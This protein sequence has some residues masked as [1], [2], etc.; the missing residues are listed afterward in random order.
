MRQFHGLTFF[1][2]STIARRFG[3]GVPVSRQDLAEDLQLR[4]ESVA[5]LADHLE[6]EGLILQVSQ[7]GSEDVGLTLALSPEKI[8]LARL[9]E[10]GAR[11]TVGPEDRTGPGWSFL[12]KLHDARRRAA[13]E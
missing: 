3:D 9:V 5:E 6:A 4:L 7:R 10:L 8:P 13:G 12:D 1:N 11:L 2:S